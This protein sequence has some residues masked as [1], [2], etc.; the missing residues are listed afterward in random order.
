MYRFLLKPR[1]IGFLIVGL[2]LAVLFTSLGFWQLRRLEQRRANNELLSSRLAESPQPFQDLITNYRADVSPFDDLSIAYRPTAVTGRYD[3]ANEVLL[4]TTDNYEGQ[5]GFYILTP[6]VLE[7]NQ[8][9]STSSRQAVLV[10]RGWVPFELNTPPVN[11]AAPP[12]ETVTVEGMVYLETT[13][14]TGF[15]SGLTP[16]DPPGKLAVTAYTDSV[17]LEQQMPHDLLPVYIRLENQTPA[18]ANALPLKPEG[19]EL[20][21]G[22][23]LGYAIQWFAFTLIGVTGYVLLIRRTAMDQRAEEVKGRKVTG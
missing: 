7:N 2:V 20:S 17:R 3:V 21:E 5:P 23:H 15:L 16:R 6:L 13:R 18:Q 22:S 19:L 4:R 11:E 1:W 9:D 8:A 12:N 14:P 10:M